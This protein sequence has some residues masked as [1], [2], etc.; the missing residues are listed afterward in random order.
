MAKE[1]FGVELNNGALIVKYGD[2]YVHYY[3]SAYYCS[4]QIYT[5][6]LDFQA[7]QD[8]SYWDGNDPYLFRYF[9]GR[10]ASKILDVD[11]ILGL[12]RSFDR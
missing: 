3:D 7:N 1:I 9:D 8:T 10:C 4:D 11:D 2:N 12:L 6:I 5:D